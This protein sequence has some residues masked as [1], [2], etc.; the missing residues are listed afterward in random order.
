MFWLM[1]PIVVPL[2]GAFGLVAVGPVEATFADESL[3]R[4]AQLKK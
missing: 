4:V 3:R 2:A 1:V